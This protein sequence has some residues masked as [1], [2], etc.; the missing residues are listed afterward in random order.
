MAPGQ[1][2]GYTFHADWFGAW[3]NNVQSVWWN[4]CI[5]K[6]LSCNSGNLGNGTM[7]KGAAQ[8]IY[9]GIPMWKHPQRLVP[10][11]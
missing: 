3:D 6:L 7:L 11:P 9:N 10:I 1:P 5:N 4:N 8:P 2:S